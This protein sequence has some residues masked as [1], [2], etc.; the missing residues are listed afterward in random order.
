MP[1]RSAF[2]VRKHPFQSIAVFGT[3]LDLGR[4]RLADGID[5]VRILD[6][7]LHEIHSSP[8]LEWR[9]RVEVAVVDTRPIQRFARVEPLVGDVVNGQ[10]GARGRKERIE[11][12]AGAEHPGDQRRLRVVAVQ[13]VDRLADPGQQFNPGL[14]E[15]HE[16]F[17][18][19]EV[20]LAGDR[21]VIDARARKILRATDKQDLDLR[22]R[23]P[24][25]EHLGLRQAGTHGDVEP[26]G[27]R[28]RDDVEPTIWW[29]V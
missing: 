22:F 27:D 20:A 10:Q 16:A 15:K 8:E 23:H 18:V 9:G 5:E 24:C 21:V 28:V 13:D 14:H 6:P 11:L 2:L 19:V 25:L 29:M 1:V 3:R 26:G 12:V 4:I 7:D 17:H